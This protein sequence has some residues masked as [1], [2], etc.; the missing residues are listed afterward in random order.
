VWV[1]HFPAN[2]LMESEVQQWPRRSSPAHSGRL[3]AASMTCGISP[4]AHCF[5]ADRGPRLA[6]LILVNLRQTFEE[7]SCF[8]LQSE[9]AQTPQ[10]SRD[11]QMIV[12]SR[13]KP[14]CRLG[15]KIASARDLDQQD[16][17]DSGFA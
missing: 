11:P 2:W 7:G 9:K 16:L 5:V 10:D 3:P 15:R 12:I 13:R 4:I 6:L 14:D 8:R 17:S 1:R